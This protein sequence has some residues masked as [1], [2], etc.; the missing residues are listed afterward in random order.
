MTHAPAVD[1]VR[2]LDLPQ[3]IIL[4]ILS[5][6]GSKDLCSIGASCTT[7]YD[8]HRDN[9][10]PGAHEIWIA[11]ES[12]GGPRRAPPDC[13]PIASIVARFGGIRSL[14]IGNGV[15]YRTFSTYS[16]LDTIC[17]CL[18]DLETLLLKGDFS[19]ASDCRVIL[20]KTFKCLVWH[21]LG[22]L[23]L[24]GLPYGDE[25]LIH[26]L[27]YMPKLTQ[28]ALTQL[29]RIETPVL[30]RRAVGR[31]SYLGT[32]L[33][34]HDTQLMPII[35]DCRK[36]V[37]LELFDTTHLSSRALRDVRDVLQ[38]RLESLSFCNGP[39][40]IDSFDALQ[41]FGN[42]QGLLKVN[43]EGSQWIQDHMVQDFFSRRNIKVLL[44]CGFESMEALGSARRRR[45]QERLWKTRKQRAEA[46]RAWYELA[47]IGIKDGEQ[48]EQS[49]L[50]WRLPNHISREQYTYQ[51]PPN[52]FPPDDSDTDSMI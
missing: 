12:L 13:C 19:K 28:L 24:H 23:V 14:T 48:G 8:L 16:I 49:K 46:R 22:H 34:L 35:N 15:P 7:L 3:E 18:P 6:M 31:L 51:D 36:L 38:P 26:Y 40:T 10:L 52:L 33:S 50:A 43:L 41:V 32:D 47:T 42:W 39:L 2:L 30:L 17:Q 11:W 44:P 29:N 37:H 45:D 4:T 21:N 9:L 25:I 5:Y 1:R 20:P 27:K